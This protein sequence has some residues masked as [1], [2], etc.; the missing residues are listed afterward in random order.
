MQP[1]S[2]HA[3]MPRQTTA[4]EF[5]AI[6]FRRKGIILGLFAVTTVTVLVISLTTPVTYVSSGRVLIKRGEQESMLTP[7]RR[8]TGDWEEEMGSEVEVVKSAAVLE[9][10][11]ALLIAEAGPART[12]P[13]I[14]PGQVDV[15]VR[16]RTNVVGIGYLDGDPLVA[17][18]VCDALVRAYVE[19][20]QSDFSMALPGNFFEA[21]LSQ[22]QKDLD[23]WIERRRDFAERRNVV[24]LAAQRHADIARLSALRVRLNEVESNLAE[25][26]TAWQKIRELPDG[27]SLD[28]PSLSLLIGNDAALIELKRRVVEQEFRVA[29]L[30]ER[31]RDDSP[32][33]VA[34]VAT[35]D[36]LGSFL[37]REIAA[38]DNASRARV[39]VL[40]ARRRVMLQ[41]IAYL[42]ASMAEMPDKEVALTEMDRRIEVLKERYSERASQGDVAR[43]TENTTPTRN[44]VLLAGA[45]PAVPRNTRDYVRLALA[46]AFSIVVG[47]G[48]AFFIDGLDLTVRTARQAEEAVELPVLAS[49][50]ER[51]RRRGKDGLAPE[52]AA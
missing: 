47:I 11:R 19:Y 36:T 21:E 34:A 8:S 9:R 15:E 7:G 39:D 48:A 26:E 32:E 38:R 20:R 35:L 40:E 4:R 17:R 6:L 5:L 25:A 41:D 44:A 12:P 45:S 16:G 10:A 31:L 50:N 24:D 29:S 18:Q 33:L 23:Y 46:P 2:P 37:R 28:Q 13:A 1:D 49:L 30:R 51:R 27:A 22:V 52:A 42:E 14:D 3:G 43:I